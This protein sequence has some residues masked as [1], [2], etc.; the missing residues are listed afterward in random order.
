MKTGTDILI[1]T[2][3]FIRKSTLLI[4]EFTPVEGCKNTISR[5]KAAGMANYGGLPQGRKEKAGFP[6]CST[7][8]LWFI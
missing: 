5:E 4:G 1:C 7:F 8:S 2:L 3:N 6:P